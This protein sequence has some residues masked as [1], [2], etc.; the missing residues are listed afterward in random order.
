MISSIKTPR[1][2][3][4][5]LNLAVSA[6]LKRI[7]NHPIKLKQSFETTSKSPIFVEARAKG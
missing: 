1:T 2:R 4:I 7:D 3:K 5:V 6:W